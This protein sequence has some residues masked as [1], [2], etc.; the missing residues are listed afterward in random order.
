V[1][2][3]KPHPATWIATVAVLAAIPLAVHSRFWLNLLIFIGIYLIVALGLTLLVGYANQISF[4]HGGFFGIGAYTSAL[5]GVNAGVPAW[6]GFACAAAAGT[7]VGYAIG[8][9]ILRLRGLSLAMATLAFG[10]IMFILFTQLPITKGPIGISGIPSPTIGSFSVDTPEQWYWLV[11]A[12]VLAVFV[13]T[14]NIAGSHVGRALRA[15][16]SSERAAQTTGIDTTALKTTVFAY[17]AGLAALAGALYAHYVSFISADS[18]TLDFSILMVVIV[19]VGGLQSLWG[20][21]VGAVFLTFV[22]EYLRGYDRYAVLLYGALLTAVF[23]Y[24]PR[25]L[26]GLMTS[27]ADE[28]VARRRRRTARGDA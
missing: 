17:S 27:A 19:A 9:P 1:L 4:G 11:L 22:P 3:R 16:G 7:L 24:F 28:L 25:G 18:F 21:V 26:F 23:L 15:L 14:R 13:L 10:Q 20:A 8:R 12:F 5:L 6:V 2:S